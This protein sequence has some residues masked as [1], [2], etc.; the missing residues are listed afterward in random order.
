MTL[1]LTDF[2]VRNRPPVSGRRLDPDMS[3][4][5]ANNIRDAETQIAEPFRGLTADG[6]V[7]PNLFTLQETGLSNEAVKRAADAWLDCVDPGQRDSALFS[8]DSDAWRRWSNIHVFLMR[9]G[10]MMED[11]T[12][13]QRDLAFDLLRESFS[14]SGFKLARNIMKLNESIREI[15]GSDDELGEWLYWLSV[16]GEPSL[17]EPWGWQFDGHHLNV[18]CFLLGG[19]MVMTPMFM[20]SEPVAVDIGKHAG[21][22]VFQ[23]EEGTALNLARTLSAEQRSK[24]IVSN[25]VPPG[26]FTGAF[27]D[28][29]E[30]RYEGIKFDELSSRQQ[31]LMFDLIGTYINRMRSD[32]A[33]LRM[34]EIREHLDETQFAWMGGT[35]EDSVFYYRVHSPVVLI[36]FDH[37]GGIFLDNDEPTR[38]HI[39]TVV[40]TPNGNDYGKDLLR[41]H[42]EQVNHHSH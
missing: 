30:M 26:V 11:M 24:A 14:P 1:E 28:N 4:Q 10:A 19:Q 38:N 39:H 12:E 3:E 41:Q 20:G 15:T 34:E 7:V 21:T 6:H 16:L 22:R 25:D 9:H 40:R 36:E 2:K 31:A 13:G 37:Q 33:E 35:D 29:F 18:N 32:H 17:D 27:R 5:M 42:R 23:A 8:V